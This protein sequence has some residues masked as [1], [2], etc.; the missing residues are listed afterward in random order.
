MLSC[1]INVIMW[2]QMLSC[3]MKCYHVGSNVIMWGRILSCGINVIM[4]GSNVIMWDQCY[5]V[6]V[7]CYHVDQCYHVGVECYHVGSN[8][9]FCYHVMLSCDVIMGHDNTPP[10]LFFL[11]TS[12][13]QELV[14]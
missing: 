1:G 6:G 12:Q 4:W 2:G 5:H 9:I 14:T 7:E 8:V 11:K 13:T 10:I 3:V